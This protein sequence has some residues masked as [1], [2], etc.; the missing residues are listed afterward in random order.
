MP[1]APAAPAVSAFLQ[2]HDD[3]AHLS[4]NSRNRCGCRAFTGSLKRHRGVVA[5]SWAGHIAMLPSA[6]GT[7]ASMAKIKRLVT[8]VR[9][10]ARHAVDKRRFKGWHRERQSRR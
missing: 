4:A 7:E 1:G 5:R 8:V 6:H 10:M 2:P 3:T 9:H